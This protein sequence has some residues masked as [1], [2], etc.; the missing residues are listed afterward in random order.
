MVLIPRDLLADL[1][2][3]GLGHNLGPGRAPAGKGVLTAFW[4]ERWSREHWSD[5]DERIASLAAEAVN[6]LLPGWA[7]SVE[8]SVV[9]RWDPSLVV[10]TPGTYERLGEFVRRI[11]PKARI[12]LAG[13]YLAQSSVNTS[14][15]AGKTAAERL[16]AVL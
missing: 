6:A 3:V 8:S 15:A 16:A 5:T 1:P 14:V 10:A 2:V 9:A 7:H 13:D 12:Q 4:M 11:D